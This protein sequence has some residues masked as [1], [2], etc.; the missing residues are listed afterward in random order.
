MPKEFEI[1]D[2][3]LAAIT[4]EELNAFIEYARRQLAGGAALA[5]IDGREEPCD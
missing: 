4:D 5:I 1:T 2:N 3:R